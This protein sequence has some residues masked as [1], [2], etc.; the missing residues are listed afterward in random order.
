[1]YIYIYNREL[2]AEGMRSV[3]VIEDTT[4]VTSDG[5]LVEVCVGHI[6]TC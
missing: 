4:I 2:K 5:T 3:H 1:M 6:Y